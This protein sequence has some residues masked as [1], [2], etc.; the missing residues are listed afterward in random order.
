MITIFTPAYNRAYIINKLYES[1]VAQTSRNFEWLIVDDG[2]TDDT[3]QL[4]EQFIIEQSSAASPVT[5][6]YVKQENGGK[7]RAINRGVAEAKGELFFI[8][9]SDDRLSPD[10]VEWA[11]GKYQDIRDNERIAGISGMRMHPD[12]VVISTGNFE[13][14]TDVTK[15]EAHDKYNMYGDYAELYKIDILKKYPF[16]DI[17]GEKFCSEGLV[18][19]RLLQSYYVRYFHKAI[20]ICDYLQD[21]LTVNRDRCRI[22]SP[23]YSMLL[24]SEQIRYNPHL[25]TKIKHSL[26]FWRFSFRS[27]YSYADKCKMVGFPWLLFA[28][29]GFFLYLMIKK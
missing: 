17:P 9:D 25:K 24:Y 7:H 13:T 19:T 21:G 2:S 1:I 8:V 20:Y 15:N 29:F 5:I 12:G 18:W 26:N 27:N 4:V 14:G 16:P 6:R 22:E 28:P 10:A 23:T 11:W 3:Q